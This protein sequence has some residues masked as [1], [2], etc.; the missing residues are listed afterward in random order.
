MNGHAIRPLQ[1]LRRPQL[2]QTPGTQTVWVYDHRGRPVPKMMVTFGADAGGPS[3]TVFTD[4]S[5]KAVLDLPARKGTIYVGSEFRY[6]VPYD[7]PKGDIFVTLP[8]CLAQPFINVPELGTLLL[9]AAVTAAGYYWK[10]EPAKVAGEVLVGAAIFT[11]IYRLS[12]L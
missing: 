4:D 12:C 5:G 2:G 7:A 11:T 6:A 9:G 3:P 8:M 10:V 1:L